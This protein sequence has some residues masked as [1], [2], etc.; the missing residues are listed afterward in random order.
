[1]KL[2]FELHEELVDDAKD[3]LLVQRLKGNDGIETIAKL[4]R[5]QALDFAHFITG[6]FGHRKAHEVF[7]T[8]PPRHWSS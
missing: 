2:V 7:E 4:G 1:M 3:D 5:E 6:L 8:L